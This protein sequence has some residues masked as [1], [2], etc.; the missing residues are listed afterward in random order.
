MID[1]LVIADDFTGALDTGVQFASAGIR[2][3]VRT[4]GNYDF[5]Q[6]SEENVQILV[7]DAETRHLSSQEAYRVVFHITKKAVESGIRHI[8]KKTDSA[9]RGNIGSE[10]TAVLDAS[11][12][13]TLP[14]IPAHPHMNRITRGGVHYIDG[15]SVE[16]SV[17]GVDPF[18]PVT[19]SYIPDII[20]LQSSVRTAVIGRGER[21]S[22]SRSREIDIYDVETEEQLQE[23]ASRL[24][25]RNRLPVMAGCA[26][27][28]SVLPGLFRLQKDPRKTALSA[29]G[30]IVVNGSL[31]PITAD[32]LDYAEAHS[33]YHRVILKPWQKL[34]AGY[35]ERP[36][37]IQEQQAVLQKCRKYRY[38]I[39]DGKDRDGS[40]TTDAYAEEKGMDTEDA[41][42]Q[43][44]ISLGKLV[45]SLVE[46]NL[47]HTLMVIGGD[48][49]QSVLQELGVCEM[50]PVCEIFPGTVISRCCCRGQE[51]QII[52]KSGG[53]G[54]KTLLEDISDFVLQDRKEKEYV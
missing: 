20:G 24:F 26:G 8:Y 11:N 48:T 22:E 6:L 45:N 52:S 35:W 2:T 9:L 23:I 28:A 34:E 32:Q 31:N 18:E 17:F 10:L 15:K 50:Y 38:L 4:G 36:E 27:F 49:L 1:I 13:R 40:S 53:F 29:E 3:V 30:L 12:C 5:Y 54:E 16:E 44:A 7:I 46:G 41:R 33:G 47:H 37:G 43:I 51:Y 25:D 14:F 21:E 19:R 42:R 39:I